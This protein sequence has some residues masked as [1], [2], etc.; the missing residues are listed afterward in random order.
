MIAA[1]MLRYGIPGWA[2]K[3]AGITALVLGLWA[4]LAWHDHHVFAQGV[5]QEKVRRDA[6]DAAD[7]AKAEAER[8]RLNQ[9]VAQAQA[10]LDAARVRVDQLQAEVDHEKTISA[11]R[12]QRLLAG[13]ERERVLIRTIP[14]PSQTGA[15]GQ[16]AGA[17]ARPMDS[18]SGPTSATLD[19][20]VASA[21]EWVR[22]TRNAALDG[23]QGC[24]IRYDALKTAVDATP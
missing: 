5:A 6:I 12:Q 2:A 24:I 23:L 1:L 19:P 20:R 4:A 11:D 17:T 18:G 10:K 9:L 14:G 21:L 8:L 22:A 7:N 16:T 3:L 15:D 13:T